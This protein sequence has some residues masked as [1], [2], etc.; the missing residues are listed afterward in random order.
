GGTLHRNVVELANAR[1]LTQ[2][3]NIAGDNIAEKSSACASAQLGEGARNGCPIFAPTEGAAAALIRKSV[4]IRI[5]PFLS[6]DNPYRLYCSQL[7]SSE[8]KTMVSKLLMNQTEHARRLLRKIRF[9]REDGKKKRVDR[10]GRMYLTSFDAK[11][12]AV[13][14]AYE[15]MPSH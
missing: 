5:Q 1:T 13:R 10:L 9:A 6:D 14:R 3:R 4:Q 7:K 8:Q 2:L 11:L 12:M 15:Q